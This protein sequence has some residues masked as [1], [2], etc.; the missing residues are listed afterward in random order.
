M[1][2]LLFSTHTITTH[3][4]AQGWRLTPHQAPALSFFIHSKITSYDIK[5]ALGRNAQRQAAHSREDGI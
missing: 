2:I 4:K 5:K 3:N 1:Y